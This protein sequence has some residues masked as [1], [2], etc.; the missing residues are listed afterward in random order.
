[1]S[2]TPHQELKLNS[3]RLTPSMRRPIPVNSA[4]VSNGTVGL[5]FHFNSG[6]FYPGIR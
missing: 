2:A 4:Q 6:H 5:K 1:V 3:G